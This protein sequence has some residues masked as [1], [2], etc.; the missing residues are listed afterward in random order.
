MNHKVYLP[1]IEMVYESLKKTDQ[2]IANFFF[3]E[4]NQFSDLSAKKVANYLHI[5]LPS[6]TRFAQKCGYK[7]YR[8]L[9]YDVENNRHEDEEL[10]VGISSVLA[11]YSALLKKASELTQDGSLKNIIQDITNYKAIYIYGIGH[12]GL[13]AKEI[14]LR[15]NRIGIACRAVTDREQIL[16]NYAIVDESSLVIA[17]SISGKS[18]AILTGLKSASQ[19][20][21]RTYILT[22][23]KSDYEGV[24]EMILVPSVLNL[25]YGNRISPQ[26]PLL[27]IVDLI[28]NDI[29]HQNG[30]L[31]DQIFKET[32]TAL[33]NPES[34]DE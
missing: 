14:E 26:F 7:G 16:V 6:L 30:E 28:Y 8:Q 20:G 27:V 11:D 5:S 31:K 2:S 18:D 12:S 25:N 19:K 3:Y 1:Q 10:N 29:M 9:I 32:L 21:A 33:D 4:A 22:T 15:F 34:P 17:L 24:D 13:V 23:Q